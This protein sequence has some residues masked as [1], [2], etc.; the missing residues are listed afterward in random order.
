MVSR[1]LR[2][3]LALAWAPLLFAGPALGA[4]AAISTSTGEAPR[5]TPPEAGQRGSGAD[6]WPAPPVIHPVA[7]RARDL[8][9]GAA[10]A[11]LRPLPERERVKALHDWVILRLT[12]GASAPQ[13]ASTGRVASCDGYASLVKSL[14]TKVGLQVEVIH[15]L[16]AVPD[17][18]PQPHAWNAVRVNGRWQLLDTTLDDPTLRGDGDET[19]TYRTDYFLVPPEVARLD[20]WPFLARWQLGAARPSREDFSRGPRLLTPALLRAGLTIVQGPREREGRTRVLVANE[21]RRFLFLALD[22]VRCAQPSDAA[23]VELECPPW[24][25]RSRLELMLNDAPEGLFRT[26]HEFDQP[27]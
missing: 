1:L 6:E 7:L 15:G 16:F 20:H 8:D 12:Y 13:A 10:A 3:L 14:G 24:T 18:E 5:A 23:L 17:G 22:G 27:R 25:R 4:G 9:L 26:V 19:S 11:L 2:P 21:H